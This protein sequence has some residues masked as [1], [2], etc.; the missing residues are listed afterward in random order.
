MYINTCFH[1]TCIFILQGFNMFHISSLVETVVSLCFRL[2]RNGSSFNASINNQSIPSPR[3][4][5]LNNWV[6]EAQRGMEIDLIIYNMFSAPPPPPSSPD[7]CGNCRLVTL[8]IFFRWRRKRR[9]RPQTFFFF[10]NVYCDCR[11][12]PVARLASSAPC[13]TNSLL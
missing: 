5:F 12:D 11:S 2:R 13:W 7:T 10:Q 4:D 8:G 6:K 9:R 1:T 3:R